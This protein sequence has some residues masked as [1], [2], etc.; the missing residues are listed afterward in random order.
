MAPQKQ[1]CSNRRD[2]LI[3]AGGT[4]ATGVI[5]AGTVGGL[6]KT[7]DS[8]AMS[9]LLPWPYKK[10]DPEVVRRRAY[11]AYPFGGCMMSAAKGMLD[12]LVE[13]VGYP[14]ET[15]PADMFRYGGSG[16][17]GWGTLCG[18]LNGALAV[19][20]LAAGTSITLLGNELIGWYTRNNFP[21]KVLDSISSR[22][23]QIQTIANSPLCHNSISLWC[24]A[25]KAKVNSIDKQERCAKVTGDT[26][27]KAVELLNLFADGKFSPTFQLSEAALACSSCHVGASSQRDDVIAKMECGACHT[28]SV[29]H[30]STSTGG[31]KNKK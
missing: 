25:A 16:A 3:G 4:I 30:G 24:T 31:G 9:P 17:I 29:T 22:P 8:H 23:N 20:N 28:M 14:W 11:D 19:M 18:S 6:F 15:V 21:S 10:L 2:L 5:A 7:S 1:I 26:A 27:A 13:E 12:T